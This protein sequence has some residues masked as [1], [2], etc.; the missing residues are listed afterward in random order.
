MLYLRPATMEDGANLLAWRND[1]ETC[2]A[3]RN[4]DPI[5]PK[6][7]NF[8]MEVN[9]RYGYPGRIVLIAETGDNVPIGVIDFAAADPA[10]KSYE[11]AITIA[12]KMRGRGLGQQALALGC[13]RLASKILKAEIR[14][15]NVGSRMIFARCGF[16]LVSE[17]DGFCQYRRE[18]A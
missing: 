10:M 2:A 14:S 6:R 9:V 16:D 18:P 4:T 12:P 13:K 5:P 1:P 3:S 17:A 11:V 15:E 8:W 7:H